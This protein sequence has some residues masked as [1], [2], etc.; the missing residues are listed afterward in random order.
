MTQIRKIIADI[1]NTN[2]K[3]KAGDIEIAIP[4]ALT[5]ITEAH[6]RQALKMSGSTL[7]DDYAIINDKFYATGA[8]AERYGTSITQTGAAK[9]HKDY[10][11]IALASMLG[12]AIKTSCKVCVYLAYPPGNI[13]HIDTLLDSL[14]NY[15]EIHVEDRVISVEVLYSYLFLEPVGGVMNVLLTDEGK[16]RKNLE[17]NRGSILAI[18]FG[19]GTT[20]FSGVFADGSLNTAVQYSLPMGINTVYDGLRS[21]LERSYSDSLIG[22]NGLSP[23]RLRDVLTTGHLR[24]KG[25]DYD[26]AELRQQELN[27]FLNR[28][29]DGFRRHAHS[30][31]NDDFIVLT[32]GGYVD[33]FEDVLAILG[34]DPDSVMVAE[35]APFAHLANVRGGAKHLT[36]LE[37]GGVISYDE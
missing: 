5:E 20:D 33:I 17:L 14:D 26:C 31:A 23:A 37:K 32:G 21:E 29:K 11:G 2:W 4:N 35:D 36:M 10:Y 1:G 27:K 28:F 22:A 12:R 25:H 6:Y 9:Y 19:G 18:D 3:L 7:P 16:L 13:N 34:F 8:M 30:G 15:Y 24:L